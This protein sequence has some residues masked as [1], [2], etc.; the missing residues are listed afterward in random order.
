MR[1]TIW[2]SLTVM[3]FVVITTSGVL[4]TGVYAPFV[5]EGAAV[6]DGMVY[7]PATAQDHELYYRACIRT[8]MSSETEES[9][10]RQIAANLGISVADVEKISELCENELDFALS[11]S[12]TTDGQA[13]ER[14][15]HGNASNPP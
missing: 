13:N 7:F 6:K 10:H 9:A 1:K 3:A 14:V 2:T 12:D 8:L 5:W 11:M 4:W 15:N